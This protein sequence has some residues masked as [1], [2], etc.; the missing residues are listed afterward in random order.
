MQYEVIRTFKDKTNNLKLVN[1]G[2]FYSHKSEGRIA[3]LIKKGFLSSKSE[4][5]KEIKHIG[6]GYYE[7][8]NGERVKGKEEAL[9]A[10]ESG[11]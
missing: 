2:D 11:E 4:P 8:P 6:G 9:S 5:E 1:K 10:L 3:E 7:L